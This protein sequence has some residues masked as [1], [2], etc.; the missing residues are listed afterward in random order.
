MTPTGPR[1]G[2]AALLPPLFVPLLFPFLLSSSLLRYSLL[3]LFSSFFFPFFLC[4]ILVVFISFLCLLL[5]F[6][7]PPFLSSFHLFLPFP[8]S[9]NSLLTIKNSRV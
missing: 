7:F 6:P 9:F 2:V 3:S 8:V 4:P 1:L 5:Y